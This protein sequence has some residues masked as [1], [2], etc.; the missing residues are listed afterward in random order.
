MR[1]GADPDVR[2]EALLGLDGLL[3]Q[4]LPGL[5]LRVELGHG[6]LALLMG[7]GGRPMGELRMHVDAVNR[8]FKISYNV[9]TR[10]L[11]GN[12]MNCTYVFF[13][14]IYNLALAPMVL[15]MDRGRTRSGINGGSRFMQPLIMIIRVKVEE[16]FEILYR[17]RLQNFPYDA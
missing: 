8:R 16:K 2:A 4:P 10:I 17:E 12:A 7:T 5:Q 15:I 11:L 1:R 14:Y 13:C 9:I 6:V 3:H